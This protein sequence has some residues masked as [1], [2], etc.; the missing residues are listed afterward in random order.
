MSEYRHAH[1]L[2]KGVH[3]SRM[4]GTTQHHDTP[5]R[6]SSVVG[7]QD[8]RCGVITKTS[9]G[10]ISIGSQLSVSDVR[11]RCELSSSRLRPI[12]FQF[13]GPLG[14]Q[15][16]LS[17]N[18]NRNRIATQ[19]VPV[20]FQAD[21]RTGWS[22]LYKDRGILVCSVAPWQREGKARSKRDQDGATVCRSSSRVN[23]RFCAEDGVSER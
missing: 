3:V 12:A 23:E 9:V 21:T 6:V 15:A 17:R 22:T 16:I 4:R 11:Y 7:I 5:S 18:R 20:A 13:S 1:R 2:T 19:L 14:H 10:C 8:R